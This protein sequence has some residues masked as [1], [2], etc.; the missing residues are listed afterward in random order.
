MTSKLDTL[1]SQ[2]LQ[3][4]H[5][6]LKGHNVF[7]TGPGGCG[8]S[9]L[10][11]TIY[12]ELPALKKKLHSLQNP[13]A[14]PKMARIQITA[15]TGCAA[16]LLGNKAKTLHSWAG[17]KLGKESVNQLFTR[18]RRSPNSM[19]HWLCTDLLIID[20]V[21]MLTAELLDKLNQLAKKIRSS[22]KPFGGM[23]VLFVGDFY[24]L[25]PVNK[26]DQDTIFAFE[27]D[28]WKE[29]IN[30]SIELTIIQRQ[31]DEIFQKII[32]E[33]RYGKLSKESCE[34]LSKR[35]GLEWK[36][37]KIRPTLLFPRRAEVDMI[38]ESNLQSL[39]GKRYYYKA[40]LLYDGLIPE[41]FNETDDQ[42]VKTLKQYDNDAPYVLELELAVDAQV[43]LIANM[44]MKLG[45]VNG[46]RGVVTGFCPATN[47]PIVEFVNG[48]VKTIGNHSWPIEEYEFISRSQVP[49]RLA[50]SLTTHKSQGSSLDSVLVDIGSGNFEFGQ[51]YV[52][53]S[54]CRSLEALYVYDFDPV[55]F[56]AHPKVRQ[57][58]ENL[59]LLPLSDQDQNLIISSSNLLKQEE[60]QSDIKLISS[61]SSEMIKAIN[62]IKEESIPVS[63]DSFDEKKLKDQP[64]QIQSSTN[65][66]YDSIPSHWKSYLSKCE[67]KLNIISTKLMTEME[68]VF[69][70]PKEYIWSAL[71]FTP[72]DSIKI[73]ILGQDPYPTPGN[74]HGLSFSI[75]P[76]IKPI[77]ASLKNI[78]KELESDLGFK[79]TTN[80]YLESWA[81]QG[82]LLLNTVLTVK[83]NEPQSHSKIG[84]EEITD[85]ILKI[86]LEHTKQTIFILWGKSAQVKKK[87]IDSY[88]HYQHRTFESPHPSPLSASKGFFGSKPFSTVNQWLLDSN[89][90]IIE[91]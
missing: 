3:V 22:Q 38:N 55:S 33:A 83:P 71:D 25:P 54:R 17:I 9:Y 63:S 53:L 87:L 49:L 12:N 74:A 78:Y 4:V 36:Q 66:L 88:S 80:G 18:I 59:I 10:I 44:D 34:L 56:R 7:L 40:R 19:R 86:I 28:A 89:K 24:Q 48:I 15:M 43:M 68:G 27:S 81:K 21:S 16:L 75:L 8:K 5:Q 20:E 52:A 42:F 69:L 32:T 35:Q 46:S 77:P 65:W 37:N 26:T 67:S 61:E 91:W 41:N 39:Q 84:W 47:L 70:P 31:K 45:L 72:L 2:Q 23:Q 29:I 14:V 30:S 73:V 58:Y 62:V 64:E 76:H 60:K 57:F 1:T 11:S 90:S 79:S 82:I 6:L 51:A 13:Y 85:E 50:Y